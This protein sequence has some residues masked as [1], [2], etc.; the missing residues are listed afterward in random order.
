MS[1]FLNVIVKILSGEMHVLPPPEA[2]A[3]RKCWGRPGL[4]L[5]WIAPGLSWQSNTE[6]CQWC[7]LGLQ[8][9]LNWKEHQGH[10]GAAVKSNGPVLQYYCGLSTLERWPRHIAPEFQRLILGF[11]AALFIFIWKKKKKK[12]HMYIYVH[13]SACFIQARIIWN[14]EFK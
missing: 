10:L 8:S 4:V 9:E 13:D 5:P 1:S 12:P 14:L 7:R 11:D 6:C 3:L 2:A